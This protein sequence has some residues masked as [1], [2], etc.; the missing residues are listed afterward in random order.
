MGGH[1]AAFERVV[2]CWPSLSLS[3]CCIPLHLIFLSHFNRDFGQ[4]LQ[5]EGEQSNQKTVK[6]L[7]KPP[8]VRGSHFLSAITIKCIAES[9]NR[10]L[11][12]IRQPS[13][14]I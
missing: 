9:D 2:A 1:K 13:N 11:C 3:Y 14:I 6:E 4:S 5:C 8:S 10:V 7:L 12:C